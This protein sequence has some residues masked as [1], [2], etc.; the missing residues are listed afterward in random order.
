MC[1]YT[2]KKNPVFFFCFFFQ[3][4]AAE[5]PQSNQTC[6]NLQEELTVQMKCLLKKEEAV[7]TITMGTGFNRMQIGMASL[8]RNLIAVGSL[9]THIATTLAYQSKYED[10]GSAFKPFISSFS[11]LHYTNDLV[12]KKI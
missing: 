11:R 2:L 9:I 3:S 8:C 1:M 12:T 4:E 10:Q 6:L 7:S 5:L